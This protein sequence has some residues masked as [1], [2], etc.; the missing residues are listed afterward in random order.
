MDKILSVECELTAYR[1]GLLTVR[2]NFEPGMLIWQESQQWCNNFVRTLSDEQVVE[3]R[4]LVQAAVSPVNKAACID[5]AT[6]TE[7]ILLTL[8]R[9]KSKESYTSD[10]LDQVGWQQ[11]RRAIEKISRIPF[12]L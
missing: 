6:Q 11:L 1:K 7:K 4:H 5:P 12:R 3:I 10:Q 9:E 8:N 2:I